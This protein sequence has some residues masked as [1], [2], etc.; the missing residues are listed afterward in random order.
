MFVKKTTFYLIFPHMNTRIFFQNNLLYVAFRNNCPKSEHFT[1]E[2][3][4]YLVSFFHCMNKSVANQFSSF[5]LRLV[6]L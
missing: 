2:I 6:I 1:C 5:I 4:V 3:F